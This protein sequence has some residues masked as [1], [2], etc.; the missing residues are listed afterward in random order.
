MCQ[1]QRVGLCKAQIRDILTL[2]TDKGEIH[3]L[4]KLARSGSLVVWSLGTFSTC[5]VLRCSRFLL[6]TTHTFI[7]HNPRNLSSDAKFDGSN[8]GMGPLHRDDSGVY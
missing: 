2:L 4:R 3:D 8:K 1:L 6:A 5:V 7:G